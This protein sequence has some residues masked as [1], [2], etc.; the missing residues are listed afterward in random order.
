V[1]SLPKTDKGNNIINYSI[2][3]R[4]DFK[5]VRNS[6]N[7]SQRSASVKGLGIKVDSLSTAFIVGIFGPFCVIFIF[8]LFVAKSVLLMEDMRQ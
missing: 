7:Y 2:N 6:D 8:W 1:D 5:L 3:F 4:E